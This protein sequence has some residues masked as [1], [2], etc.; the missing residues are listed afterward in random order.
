MSHFKSFFKKTLSLIVALTTFLY[1]GA[2]PVS[3]AHAD[4]AATR[5]VAT[6][7][8][9]VGDCTSAAVPCRTIQY[10]VNQSSSGNSILVAQGIYT[11]SPQVDTCSSLNNIKPPSV[12]CFVDKRLTIFGGYSITNWSTANPSVNLTVI[13]GQ[14]TYRGVAA[15]GYLTTTAYLDMQ[16]FTIQN[17]RAQG[18]TSY[19]TSGIGGG[20]LV[21]NAAVTLKNVVFKNNKAIGQNTV[22]GAGGPADGAGL[23]IEQSPVGTT[24]LLQHVTFDSNQSLGGSGPERGGVAFGALFIFKSTVTV[25][26]AIFTNNLAQAGS[27]T[28]NGTSGGLNADALG[29]A[30]GIE[31]SNIITLRR[32]TITGNQIWGGN[33]SQ[34]GGGAYGAGIL[35]EDTT[36]FIISDSY[37]ANNTA[38]AGN[39][40]T[41]GNAASGGI[42]AQNNGEVAIERVKILSNSVIGGSSTGGGS[43]GLGAGGGLYIFA[44]RLGGTYHATIK[45]MIIADNLADQGSGITSSGNGGGGGIVIHGIN[46]D[47]SNTTIERNSLG[48]I[49]VLGQGLVVQPWGSLPATVNI[50]HSIIANHTGGGSLAT[51]IAVQQGSTLIF[52]HGLFSGNTKNTNADGSPVP[53]GTINGIATMSSASS[54]GFVS[55]GSP[56]YNYHLRIDSPAKD[57]ATGSTTADDIDGQSRPYNS[58]PDLG[59]DEYWPFPLSTAPGDGRLQLNWATGVSVLTGGVSGYE[60][61]VTCTAGANPPDQ[62]SCGQPINAGTATAFTL[63]GLSNFKQYT[64]II[65]ARDP[66]QNLIATS[67]TVIAFPT[68]LLL[69]MPIVI[70]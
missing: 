67:N 27:S 17:G 23:R 44:T 13:D 61:L 5:Y 47:I 29:G 8:V 69:Y 55:P 22:S 49:M 28:G 46:A 40:R 7:G 43:A 70:R 10:A 58:V 20:M 66:S 54:A 6:T 56:N 42:Q 4:G 33:A 36:L 48:S 30:I 53:A 24:S 16:G 26:D 1:L 12:I 2:I 37:L 62:G 11:Y 34:Y 45:N 65:N 32:L 25:E 52:N 9:D 60:I 31:L 59:A 18:P 21:Q 41:G 15:I 39:A 63:T 64:I 68:D 38:K 35:V 51:A 57:Q 50:S 14:N 3:S 19:D